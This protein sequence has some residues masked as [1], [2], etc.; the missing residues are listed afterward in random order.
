MVHSK[1]NINTLLEI[2]ENKNFQS[3]ITLN[4]LSFQFLKMSN[5]CFIKGNLFN[6]L[7]IIFLFNSLWKLNDQ[8]K[9][10]PYLKSF[11]IKEEDGFEM[12][13]EKIAC[14]IG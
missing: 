5:E 4:E 7:E 6:E 9:W 1:E 11:E 8:N 10:N 14:K 3:D 12:V 2:M 13:K